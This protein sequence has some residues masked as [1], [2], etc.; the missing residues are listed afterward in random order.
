ML[1]RKL[2]ELLPYLY[3]LIGIASSTLIDSAIVLVSSILLIVTGVFV[4]YMRRTFRKSLNDKF[5]VDQIGPE[6]VVADNYVQRSGSE[7]RRRTVSDWPITDDV[8][9]AVISDRRSRE[10]RASDP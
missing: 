3:I 5:E 10:R 9:V 4:L 2:Y 1:P 8:G 7:R 6:P